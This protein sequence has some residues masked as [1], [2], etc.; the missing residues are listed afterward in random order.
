MANLKN[1]AIR[2]MVIDQC[3]RNKRRK[4]STKDLM[5]ACNKALTQEGYEEVTSLNTIRSDMRAIEQRWI[6]YPCRL[7]LCYRKKINQELR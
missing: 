1:A 5:E 3:L 4:Y 6:A 2:E 7:F